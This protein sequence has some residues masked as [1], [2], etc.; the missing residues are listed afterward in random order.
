[1]W[2]LRQGL[3]KY[4]RSAR[5]SLTFIGKPGHHLAIVKRR[6]VKYFVD[7]WFYSAYGIWNRHHLGLGLPYG[8][9]WAQHPPHIIEIV[10][11]FEEAYRQITAPGGN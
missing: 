5:N 1:M 4:P 2:V 3:L 6:Q 7:E 11:G 9:G 10:E 8:T